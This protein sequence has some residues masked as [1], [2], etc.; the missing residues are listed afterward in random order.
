MSTAEHSDDANTLTTVQQQDAPRD[1]IDPETG[2]I[3]VT[4][5]PPPISA[6]VEDMM[7]VR[8]DLIPED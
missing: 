2:M 3:R 4:A 7:M 5:P 1:Y 8:G 6:A